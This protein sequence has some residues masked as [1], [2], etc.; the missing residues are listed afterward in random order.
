MKDTL[1]TA[2]LEKELLEE[3]SEDYLGLWEFV[4]HLREELGIKDPDK[5]REIAMTMV[6]DLLGERLMR[7]GVPGSRT[8][9]DAWPLSADESI[10]RIEREW[11]KLNGEPNIGD[12][13]WFDITERGKAYL[14]RTE[15]ETG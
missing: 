1:D 6:R 10:E 14:A 15:D 5:R 3:S 7:A 8:R 11:D 2:R 13:A 4:W 12:V 9:F